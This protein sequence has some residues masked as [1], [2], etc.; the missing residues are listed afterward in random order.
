MEANL[1]FNLN[2]LADEARHYQCVHSEEMA[3]VLWEIA[4]N[5][6]KRVEWDVESRL[7]NPDPIDVV[8]D[9]INE[10]IINSNININKLIE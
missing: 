2:T 5:L 6:R 1:T 4:N 8:F 3:L 9:M 7:D 10:L